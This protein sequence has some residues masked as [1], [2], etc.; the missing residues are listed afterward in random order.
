[1]SGSDKKHRCGE[2]K[3][4]FI[5][6]GIIEQFESIVSNEENEY[7]YSSILKLI[8]F[9]LLHP[10]N[11]EKHAQAILRDRYHWRIK[12]KDKSGNEILKL[13]PDKLFHTMLELSGLKDNISFTY[14]DKQTKKLLQ[15]MD[16]DNSHICSLH[17]RAV[18]NMD[19]KMKIVEDDEGDLSVQ[20]SEHEA[21]YRC[22][23]RHIRNAFAHNNVF[24]FENGNV[25][26]KDYQRDGYKTKD[27][28][29]TAAILMKF[30]TLF[31][32]I[33]LIE[34]DQERT[35]E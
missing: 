14:T 33:R 8:D 24:F 5:D 2:R 26:L 23:F 20:I 16:L 4:T 18:L 31:E 27:K 1:M 10:L 21:G 13:Y 12:S 35:E 30:D 15:A 32:W 28:K 7:S 9:Y 34:T 25:L 22:L 6:T 19:C 3:T 17:T 29:V 11:E